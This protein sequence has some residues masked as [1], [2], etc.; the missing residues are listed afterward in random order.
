MEK[1]NF[2]IYGRPGNSVRRN[3]QIF[4][5]V[6]NCNEILEKIHPNLLALKQTVIAPAKIQQNVGNPQLFPPER[7]QRPK[8][9]KETSEVP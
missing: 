2:K 8:M 9:P 6:T 1:G 7:T 3:L 5:K 4:P